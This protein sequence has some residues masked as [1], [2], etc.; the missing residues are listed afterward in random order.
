MKMSI[1]LMI[2]I[3]RK[4][5]SCPLIERIIAYIAAK[6]KIQAVKTRVVD[7]KYVERSTPENN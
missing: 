6:K 5:S 4:M 3:V 1:V 2:S 7:I